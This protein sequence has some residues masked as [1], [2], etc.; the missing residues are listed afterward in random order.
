MEDARDCERL[1]KDLDTIYEWSKKWEMEFNAKKCKV[2]ELG[3]SKRRQTRSY[4]M[5]DV[6]IKKTKDEKDLGITISDN[7]SPEKHVNNIVGATYELLRKMKRAFTYMDEEMMKLIE[8]MI[9]P[10]LDYTPTV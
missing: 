6:E 3:K 4:T 7:L 5:G 10:R 1:Q 2:M 8:Y 9:R